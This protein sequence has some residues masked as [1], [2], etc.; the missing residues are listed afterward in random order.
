M[1]K[2]IIVSAINL[3]EAGPLTVLQECVGY[4]SANLANKYEIIV[5]VNRKELLTYKNIKYL[6]FPQSKKSWINRLYYEYFYFSKLSRRLNPFLWLSLHDIIPN[7]TAQRLAVY[8]HNASSFYELSLKEAV[9]D[10]RF[11]LFNLF[12]KYL[13]MINIKKADS[14]IVQQDWLRRE[15]IKLFRLKNVIVAHPK[16]YDEH[17]L[18]KEN[19]N[20]R[21]KGDFIF[22]YP[23]FPRFFKNFEV[24]CRA[25][26][27]LLKQGIANFKIIFTIFGNENWYSKSIYN[28]F[29]HIKNIIFLGLQKR[30]DI[31]NLY[32]A[33]GCLIFP[34]KLET[35]GLPITEFEKYNKPI[36]LADLPYAH[37][38]L[39]TYGK[40][41]F[42]S[43]NN[44]K[45]LADAMKSV[46][47]ETATFENIKSNIIAKPF[48]QDWKELFEILLSAS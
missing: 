12:Y 35:W 47:D 16:I 27:V 39:G 28:S 40:A 42:F 6:E 20:I 15:F 13:Y 4:L 46:M 37:E 2:K 3:L 48:S 29:K 5:L 45:Q 17:P 11:A 24:V 38:T 31:I 25:S 44:H 9:I 1:K 8:C 10:P 18:K 32:D 23:A 26:E 34:S 41:K 22:F 7:V 21:H 43:P 36:L 19:G 33:A 30:E 14:V